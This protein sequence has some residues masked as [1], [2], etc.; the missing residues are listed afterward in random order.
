LNKLFKYKKLSYLYI[1]LLGVI[2]SFTLPPFN[3][4]AINFITIS[5]FFIFLVES[6]FYIKNKLYYF[7]Y[8]WL[9]GFGYFTTSLYWIA[10]SLT[11]D[12]DLKY[13]I[14]LSVI[15]VP[16]FI[17]LFFALPTYLFSY[18]LNLNKINLILSFSILFAFFEFLRGTILTGFPWNLFVYSFSNNITFL[19]ALSI[20]G[21][22]GLNLLCITFFLLPCI[23]IYKTKNELIF[24]SF[25][26]ILFLSLI[27]FGKNRLNDQN[28][29]SYLEN[30]ISIKVISSNI[31][32]ERFYNEKN[33]REII[34]QLIDLS[35]PNNNKPTI[36]VWPE[37]VITASYLDDIKKYKKL[38]LER[39][40]KEHKII[41]GLN[42]IK[43][44][45]GVKIYNSLV[46][47][48][49]EL[50]LIS[51][52][53]KNK[54]VPFGEF[55]PFENFLSKVGLRKITNSYQSF[56]RDRNREI[57]KINNLKILPLICYEIIYSGKLSKNK[58]F[59]LLVN[60]SEDG[61]FGKS[62]GPNQHFA[63]LI[64]RSIE[65]GKSSIRSTNNGISAFIDPLGRI[66][67]F[68]ESTKS[69]AFI[70]N[71]VPSLDNKTF[72]S[73]YGNNIFF[74][75]LIIYIILIFF[76]Q[77]IKK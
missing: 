1:I 48:D 31:E 58:D 67:N 61:W 36:F 53:H 72:F 32:I 39:F 75:L 8:G 27:I 20:L 2:S 33:E 25:S 21:T 38:F 64:F 4:F 63:H 41:L 44:E 6:R 19:Q 5:L 76:L 29:I 65:E 17:S 73:Q 70:V 16:S 14:P 45:D 77:R 57:I 11:F 60:I 15:L 7:L 26:I 51:L 22:Y 50:N 43:Y 68:K 13:L 28:Q 40:T 18:F 49:N 62:I 52:Y 56:S 47:L 3:F 59:D 24:L 9:F 54:L 23:L 66:I 69:G 74:N 30:N 37:G 10:I 34:N 35:D 42:D 12:A 46:V 55:L 71:Q